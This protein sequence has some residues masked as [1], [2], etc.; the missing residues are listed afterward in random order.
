MP[1][2]NTIPS[3]GML[4]NVFYNLGTLNN[5][6]VVTLAAPT[7]LTHVN[8]YILRFTMPSTPVTVSIPLNITFNSQPNFVAGSTYEITIIDD[9]GLCVEF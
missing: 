5:D 9:Y 8:E 7:D 6:L 3:G 2:A 1:I 4:P